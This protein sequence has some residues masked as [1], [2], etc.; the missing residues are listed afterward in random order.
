MEQ[1]VL[2][3]LEFNKVLSMLEERAASALGRQ[4]CLQL[5]PECTQEQVEFA[6]EETAQAE[7]LSYRLGGNPVPSFNDIRPALARA[8]IGSIL[9]A[10]ELLEVA[11]ILRVS[12]TIQGAYGNIPENIFADMANSLIV[13]RGIE[14]D[15]FA[16]ILSENEIADT[17]SPALATIRRHIRQC[18]ERIRERLNSIIHS[19]TMQKYLQDPIITIRNDRY[20][21][22][23]KQEY[24]QSVAGLIHD[25]SSSGATL[26]IEPMQVVEINNDLKQLVANERDEIERIL[27]M[28][29][30][31]IEPDC[32]A[33]SV[34]L[35][36]LAKMD[37]AFAKGNLARDMRAVRPA[38][39]QEMYLNIVRGRH[40]LIAAQS[41]VPI[42]VWLGDKFSVLVVTGP[43][44]GGKTVALKTIGLFALMAQAGLHIPAA[45]GS[46]MPVFD[47][48]FADIGDEQSIEQSLSTFSSHMTNI[49]DI[50]RDATPYSLVL[51]DELGAGTD[52]TEGAA[53]AMAILERMLAQKTRTAATTHYSELKEFALTQ[54]GVE[55]ASAEFNIETLR[56]TYRL[57][58]GI[59]GKSNAFEISRKLGLDTAIIGS[60]KLHMSA[61]QLHF[62]DVLSNAEYNRQIT[63]K[64]REI[65]ENLH[66]EVLRLHEEAET[67][68]LRAQEQRDTAVRKAKDEARSI[69]VS[70]RA[71]AEH[72]IANLRK[73][74]QEQDVR[75][76]DRLM[77]QSQTELKHGIDAL[78]PADMGKGQ[79]AGLPLANDVLPG[80]SV[81]VVS[82]DKTGTVLGKPDNKGD[83]QV[84][85]GIMKLTVNVKDLRRAKQA[86]TQ[87]P[88]STKGTRLNIIQ[89]ELELDLRGQLLDDAIL[90][91]DR[92]LD[93]AARAALA[94]VSLIHGKGTGALRTGLH[95]YLRGHPHVKAF[96][97]GN[98]GEGEAGVT[99]ITLK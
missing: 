5:L 40:P 8:K 17:A 27:A 92:F 84:Q 69:L 70:A 82:L 46:S 59:P 49:V 14:E 63:E 58:I 91:T 38:I 80:E 45:S 72:I 42:D 39:N 68:R 35:E 54:E 64:E 31:R 50:I 53:L 85:I 74:Q 32:D 96:R 79:A 23:V 19:A 33:I 37:F 1:R 83:V 73:L 30:A 87:E 11:G 36:M 44:T 34:N 43:N 3:V 2:R 47:Q 48:V 21:I 56:P 71:Q 28:L 76:R 81:H 97:L 22:P 25:Q 88:R 62:D 10:K 57:S 4:L 90:E 18:N 95:K 61:E 60:A 77:V 24:R 6:Q 12:R 41:V 93:R 13:L 75:E 16:A 99:I 89:A 29:T 7:A 78:A 20:V 52:P 65:A 55:N 26:F 67:E 66:K 15:I 94:E 51:F 98:F 9:S 86:Q